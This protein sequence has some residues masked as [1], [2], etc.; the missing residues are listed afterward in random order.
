MGKLKLRWQLFDM[1]S[2][3]HPHWGYYRVLLFPNIGWAWTETSNKPFWSWLR[4]TRTCFVVLE[5]QRESYQ[6]Q[7]QSPCQEFGQLRP[8]PGT[9]WSASRNPSCSQCGRSDALE[10]LQMTRHAVWVQ[11]RNCYDYKQHSWQRKNTA[12]YFSYV[13]PNIPINIAVHV[14]SFTTRPTRNHTKWVK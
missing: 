13:W 14:D 7:P 4:K 6:L 3:P 5:A 11:S 2:K 12:K 8:S 10:S 9:W 1:W